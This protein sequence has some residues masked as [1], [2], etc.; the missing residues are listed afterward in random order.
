ML[1]FHESVTFDNCNKK[2]KNEIKTL[3][4]WCDYQQPKSSNQEVLHNNKQEGHIRTAIG[5]VSKVIQLHHL[6]TDKTHLR[7]NKVVWQEQKGT[8]TNLDVGLLCHDNGNP[9]NIR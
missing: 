2:E 5:H 6:V 9:S 4:F 8:E 3:L 7:D 1:N